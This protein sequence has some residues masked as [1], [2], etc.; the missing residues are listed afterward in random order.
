MRISDWSSDVCSSDLLVRTKGWG[1]ALRLDQDL[2]AVKF[3]SIT[4]R[5]KSLHEFNLDSDTGPLRQGGSLYQS[6]VR[7]WKQEFQLTNQSDGN[8]DWVLGLRSEEHTSELQSVLRNS[9]A[10]FCFQKK[11][12]H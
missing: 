3:V 2:G 10:A 12:N 9:Y 5:R 6:Y 11:N 7:N 1:L 4:P 8:L